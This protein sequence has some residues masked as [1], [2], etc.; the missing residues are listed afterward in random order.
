MFDQYL[1]LPE[2]KDRSLS[3][4]IFI[5][6]RILWLIANPKCLLRTASRE[7]MPLVVRKK[8]L[9]AQVPAVK[10]VNVLIKQTINC[11]SIMV[12]SLIFFGEKNAL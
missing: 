9:A 11:L 4:D 8:V 2:E 1:Y 3:G 7:I 10:V 6:R 12:D 5:K